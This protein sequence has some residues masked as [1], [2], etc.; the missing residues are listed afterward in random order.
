MFEFLV[1]LRWVVELMEG[2]EEI[3]GVFL[4]GCGLVF[5]FLGAR[6]CRPLVALSFAPF[7]FLLGTSLPIEP[8]MNLLAG[9]LVCMSLAVASGLFVRPALGVLAGGWC[10]MLLML[11]LRATGFNDQLVLVG[12]CLAFGAAVSLTFVVHTELCAAVTSFEG[13]LLLLS[14][15]VILFSHQESLWSHIRELLVD[16]PILGS[17]ILLAGTVGG[18]YAQLAEL[19]KK[20]LGVTR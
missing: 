2:Q 13:S 15:M 11:L 9:A 10:A 19:Q 1:S 14:G 18:S 3:L 6:L 20:R 17:F 12:G 4:T 16:N 8:P 5:I 7:G